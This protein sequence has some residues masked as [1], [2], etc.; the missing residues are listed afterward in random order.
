MLKDDAFTLQGFSGLQIF[1]LENFESR[2]ILMN[3]T[4]QK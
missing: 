4:I 1:Q 2:E 3:R